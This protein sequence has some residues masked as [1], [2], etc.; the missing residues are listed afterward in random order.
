[1]PG[2]VAR[3]IGVAPWVLL[4]YAAIATW[5]LRPRIAELD[6]HIIAGNEPC[7]TVPNAMAWAIGWG[8]SRIDALFVGYWDAPIFHPV[9]GAFVLS[10]AMPVLSLLVWPLHAVGAPLATCVDALVL[11][12]LVANGWFLRRLLL[13]LRISQTPAMLG[14][15][16][17]V[18]LPF[19]QLE[20]GVL[21]LLSLWPALWAMTAV[22]DLV[23]V[24]AGRPWRAGLE[25]GAA[26]VVGYGCCAQLTLFAVMA[27]IP[28]V[29]IA[30]PWPRLARAQW[31]GLCLAIAIGGAGV[32]PVAMHQRH[33]LAGFALSRSERVQDY[34]AATAWQLARVPWSPVEP[35]PRRML[36][37]RFGERALDPGPLR[38][39]L[40]VAGL[41]LGLRRRRWRRPAGLLAGVAIASVGLAVLPR[42]VIAGWSPQSSLAAIVPGLE[43]VRASFRAV[44]FAQ[45]A[46]IALT[47]LALHLAWVRARASQRRWPRLAVVVFGAWALLE[48]VPPPPKW[49]PLPDHDT[50]WQRWLRHEAEPGAIAVLPFPA[51]GDVCEHADA[52]GQMLRALDHGHPLVNGYSSFFPP[53]YVRTARAVRQLPDA[54]GTLALRMIHTRFV[55]AHDGSAIDG[56]DAARRRELG[57]RL[58]LRDDDAGVTIFE[59]VEPQHPP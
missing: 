52:T 27:A 58:R 1:M 2:A 15:A 51:G 50:A 46:V 30:T 47:M 16:I 9:R 20:L 7:D 56:L 55:V 35:V 17:V 5:I 12:S 59:L 40:A 31:G 13:H 53:L 42:V 39:L 36:A 32:L 23:L 57:L 8:L 19:T 41:G 3:R 10:E 48:L 29:A 28:A 33:V 25:L 11:G 18:M 43:H 4:G 54:R 44:A 26:V 14:G 21:A 6:R 37:R 49:I 22:S 24:R 34:G 38:T 45:L